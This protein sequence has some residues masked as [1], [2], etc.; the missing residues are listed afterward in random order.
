MRGSVF[1]LP[2]G[3]KIYNP[4]QKMAQTPVLIAA[5][6]CRAGVP[7]HALCMQVA[8]E[9]GAWPT[10]KPYENMNRAAN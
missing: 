8:P 9:D 10:P 7:R 3:S 4:H 1:E 5:W 2:I 6:L